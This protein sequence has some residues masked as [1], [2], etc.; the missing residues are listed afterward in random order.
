MGAGVGFAS[1]K[2]DR[3]V[4]LTA[5]FDGGTLVTRPLHVAGRTLRLN[6]KADYGSI[7]VEVLDAAGQVRAKSKPWRQDSLNG[8]VEWE[9]G[10][11][12]TNEPVTLRLQ[13]SNAHLF[14]LWSS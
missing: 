1:I 10:T 6:A 7:V 14:A 11:L 2:R 3:F 4:S 5:S 8:A 9:T 12:P 13:L